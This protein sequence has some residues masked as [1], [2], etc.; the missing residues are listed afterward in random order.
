MDRDLTASPGNL[1]PHRKIF[2][3]TCNW[4][5]PSS[6]SLSISE[7]CLGLFFFCNLT[8]GDGR[9]QLVPPLPFSS[10]Q[11]QFL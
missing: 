3:L 4:N 11:T 2:F 8:L 5:F 9:M 1:Q 7:K 10:K 6:P